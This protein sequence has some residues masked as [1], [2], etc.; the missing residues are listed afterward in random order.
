[1]PDYDTWADMHG[2]QGQEAYFDDVV[3]DDGRDDYAE[4]AA[5]RAEEAEREARLQTLFDTL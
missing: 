2:D 5:E 4:W 3:D 1:M